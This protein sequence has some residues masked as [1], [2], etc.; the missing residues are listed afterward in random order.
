MLGREVSTPLSLLAPPAPGIVKE[1]EWVDC[2]QKR[3]AETHRTVVE[4]LKANQRLGKAYTDRR[5]KGYV[6]KPD[7]LVWLY[8]PKIKRGRSPKLNANRWT[9]PWR[10][11]TVISTCVYCIHKLNGPQKRVVNVDR[12]S[13]Y[14]ERSDTRF[15]DR[16][17]AAA[18]DIVIPDFIDNSN[19]INLNSSEETAQQDSIDDNNS[20]TS[21]TT[22]IYDINTGLPL[23]KSQL[24]QPYQA[25]QT[26]NTR[27]QRQ[28]RRP[29][30]FQ[31]P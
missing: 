17:T 14:I 3:F 6:F 13:P 21:D 1:T 23:P 30:R 20:V 9:G 26:I 18:D 15:P 24:D 16:Q 11:A 29:R 2:L 10:I 8:E 31:S 28:S 5:Q 4:V 22:I 7:D 19:V 25:T 12:L 27:P